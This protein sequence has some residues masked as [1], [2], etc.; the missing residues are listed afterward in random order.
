M[1]CKLYCVNNNI[2]RIWRHPDFVK[3]I[4]IDLLEENKL[5][6]TVEQFVELLFTYKY[7]HKDV[8]YKLAKNQTSNYLKII[9]V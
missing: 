8:C 9:F 6:M 7:P 4:L 3:T 5:N 2:K 1:V